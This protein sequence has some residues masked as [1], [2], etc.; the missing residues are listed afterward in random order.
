M[1]VRSESAIYSRAGY[2]APRCFARI[3]T[4]L[5]AI[6]TLTGRTPVSA[7]PVATATPTPAQAGVIATNC[8]TYNAARRFVESFHYCAS[9]LDAYRGV[10]AGTKPPYW[11]FAFAQAELLSYQA[12]DRAGMNQH[13]DALQTALT[14][15]RMAIAVN[16]AYD[17]DA[18]ERAKVRALTVQLAN[19]ERVETSILQTPAAVPP[20]PP[21]AAASA[22]RR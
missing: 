17:L 13:T 14:A 19:F 8:R 2:A 3:A 22:P 7:D 1:T 15:H 21:P 4:A 6:A 9:A 20:V 12:S 5:F 11:Y 10:E 18:G 16:R